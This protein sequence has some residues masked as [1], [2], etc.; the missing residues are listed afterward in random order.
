[1]GAKL[2]NLT[3]SLLIGGVAATVVAPPAHANR[4]NNPTTTTTQPGYVPPPEYGQEPEGLPEENPYAPAP[5][6][7]PTIV[8]VDLPAVTDPGA[9]LAG[10]GDPLAP[11]PNAEGPKVLDRSETRPEAAPSD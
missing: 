10:G 11:A 8:S 2:R 6:V 9:G 1:M 7:E 4:G 5:V 3:L